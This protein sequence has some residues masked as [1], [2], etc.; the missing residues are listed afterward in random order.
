MFLGAECR[1]GEA[2][3][4]G[5]AA[6]GDTWSLGVC[7][8]S[9]LQGKSVL[10]AGVDTDV[11]AVCETH[12]TT[13]ARSVLQHSL[14][15]HSQ[16]SHVITGSPLPARINTNDAGQYSG[17]ATIARV[18]ARALCACWPQDLF[19]T[20]RVQ[21]TGTFIN[22]TWITGAVMYG[23]PQGKVH[24]NALARSSEMLE[25]L[26]S[27]MTQVASG[28]R[29]LCGDLNHEMDQ[30]P[31]LQ[32]LVQ[33]GWREAQDLEC[34]RTGTQPQPT[35]KGCTRKDM[36]WISPE[37]VPFFRCAFVDHDRFA[38]HSVLRAFF[39]LDGALSKRYLWPK[40]KPVPWNVVPP[41]D[42]PV[43]FAEGSPTEVYKQLWQ[44][45]EALAKDHLGEQWQYQMQGRGQRT[46]P[47][48]RRGWAA[49]P[50]KGR[51]SDFQPAFHGYNVQHSRWLRQL[52]RLHN[53]HRWAMHHYGTAVANQQ[54]H[55]TMLWASV[56]KATGF[57]PSFQAWWISRQCIGLQDPASV[58][59]LP[60]DANHA[61]QLCEAFQGEL[62]AFERT[63]NAA[64]K[65]AKVC[66]HK[67][68]QNLIYKDTKRPTPEPVTSLLVTKKAQVAEIRPEDSAVLLDQPVLFDAQDPVVVGN[69][70]TTIIHATADTLYLSDIADA[71][72]GHQVTQT[73]PVGALDEVFAVFHTQW[74]LRWCKHDDIPHS[75]WDQ[76]VRFAR[77]HL[78]RHDLV[79]VNITPDLL[80]AEVAS[81]KSQ[82]ATG[83]DGVSRADILHLDR[84]SL[85]SLC[86]LYHR[87]CSDGS[88]PLQ[89]VTGSV[90]SLAKREGAASTQDY[91][92]I[93]IFSMVYRAFSSLHARCMLDQANQWCHPDIYGNRKGHQTSQL[94]RVLVSSIQQA[95]DQNQCLSGLTADIEKCFNCLPRYPIIAAALQVGTPLSTMTAWCGA[96]AAMTRRFKVRD[97]YSTGFTTSTGLAEGC[98]LSCY[99]MLIMD[100]IMHRYIA[101]Q[102]P[103]LRVLSF[104][105]NWDFI[106]WNAQAATQQLDALLEFASL[107]DLTVDRQ[108]TYAWSTS[109][110]VRANLRSLGIP[111]KHAAKDLGAHVAFSRQHT[112][113]TVTSR[114]D[115]LTPFW[116]QLRQSRASYRSKLRAL[117][118]VAWPRGLF[119]VESAPI[120]DNT[121]LCQRRHANKALS[122]DKPGVNPMLLLGLVEAYVDPEFVALIR[123]VG[124]TR[125]N[126]PLDF[127]ASDLFPLAAGIT[128]S[129]PSSPAAV[130]LGRIQ[131]VGIAIKPTGHWEDRIGLFHPAH[132]NFAELCHR[133]Q[134]QWHQYVCAA[135]SHRKDFHGLD[136]VDTTT[137]RQAIN[138]LAVDDQ[139]M[140]R[141]SLAGG[142]FTQDAHVHWNEG[143][144]SCKWCGQLDSLRHRYFECPNTLDLRTSLAPDVLPLL[145]LL[146]EAMVLRSWA[147]YPPT[148]LAWLRLLDSVPCAVPSLACAFKPG[149]LNHVFTDGS[150]LWQADP[151]FRVAS[152]AAILADPC[153]PEWNFSCGGVLGAG[154]VPGLCQTSYRGELFALAVILHHAAL[155]AF[156]VKVYCDCLGVVN[157][158]HRLT[159]GR[160]ALKPNSASADLWTWVLASVAMLGTDGCEVVKIP[161]HRKLHQAK[162]RTEVWQFWHNNVVDGVAKHAN[163]DRSP[164]FWDQWKLH[165][166]QTMAARVLHEQVCALHIAVARRSVQT[167]AQVT[168][169]EVPIA[170]PRHLRIFPVEFNTAAW[171]GDIPLKFA[172]AYGAGLARRICRW[173]QAR[174]TSDDAGET[175]WISFAHLYVDYQ[176]TFG[177]PGPVKHGAQWLDAQTRPYLDPEQHP[178]LVRLKW[179]RRCLKMFWKLT[180]QTVGMNACKV[181]G[182][183]IQS[184]VIA[185]S[186]R[187]CYFSWS[188]AEHWIA[189]ACKGPCCRGTRALEALPLA[190]RQAKFALLD[191][192]LFHGTDCA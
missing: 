134:W 110:E 151:A 19:E 29:Y 95:Y 191:E 32:R 108:K 25:F 89:T 10:L 178:F 8:P 21:I 137:T 55:G 175:R 152:W 99:G 135:V 56:L 122:M 165:V 174:T 42:Q 120:S 155:G 160:T 1:I 74:K 96:L 2:K 100:D 185:A 104:V 123:T 107:A 13:T 126:C 9:G 98:A 51:S 28:P 41:L 140:L 149:V 37:L 59:T 68:N 150:C 82:A 105:D 92:P 58:P 157:K 7:N 186:I 188:G 61:C 12:L 146:P 26:I 62:R 102:Y 17:V 53:Y 18:P 15:S 117:R 118:T 91:R 169:D 6:A 183:S 22:Q 23:Y 77:H 64:K 47:L 70:P 190:R 129:P 34:L 72:V 69:M 60:P 143:T 30:L 44:A 173:W 116:T 11:I 141:L 40:P 97:S 114:L 189:T 20:G 90:A 171:R 75:H 168:L 136:M 192:A 66:A 142:L 170:Q 84:N 27:H 128:N 33:L 88:W 86:Q 81:K 16:Y 164:Q 106:T 76:L 182:D 14:K 93:T 103:L 156:R 43:D 49:P 101:A 48:V 39:A 31:A 179:F 184:F 176:L 119:A 3:T 80:R 57:G 167:E 63:L 144:G 78:P 145:D 111:V 54:L 159:S 87:A 94:W 113:S 177:C 181:E 161:A 79:P 85:T 67:R 125:L 133:L 4:P 138:R 130:L 50:R 24:H 131:K 162:S 112:N 139:S 73:Q 153:S 180:G 148:H 35:C 154:H 172:T 147:I 45:K 158:Y 109:A 163:L 38:D 132:V 124:E 5:P 115:A 52:R 83:L 71:Q 127:W 65:A 187:W 166:D 36:L 121:W 46:E